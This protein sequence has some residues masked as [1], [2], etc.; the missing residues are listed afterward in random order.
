MSAQPQTLTLAAQL[1]LA[2]PIQEPSGAEILIEAL[3]H[4]G[5]DSIF[6]YPGGAV[7][8]IYD[9]LWCA[10]DRV[11]H[12]SCATNRARCTWPKV[13]LSSGHRKMDR[14]FAVISDREY[15]QARCLGPK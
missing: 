9:E 8:H 6:G 7:L 3:V 5:V 13:I 2:D 15:V 1:P 11:T 4:E 12:T 14:L 10:R